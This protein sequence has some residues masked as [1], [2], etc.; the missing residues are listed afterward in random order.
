MIK[1]DTKGIILAKSAEGSSRPPEAQAFDQ[2][3][4]DQIYVNI[5]TADGL[6]IH[7]K[8]ERVVK[9]VFFLKASSFSSQLTPEDL[10]VVKA[11]LDELHAFGALAPAAKNMA[12]PYLKN[13]QALYDT[14]SAKY[15]ESVAAASQQAMTEEEKAAFDKKCDL[16][17]LD[18]LANKD[19]I[20]RS[21]EI[22]KD[23][24]PLASRSSQLA[25]VLARWNAQKTHALQLADEGKALWKEASTAHA[26]SFSVL[27]Q[28]SEMPDFP[29]DVKKK[30][31]D[32][33]ARLDQFRT[34]TDFPQ[35]ITYCQAEI[36]AYFLLN[37]LPKMVEKIKDKKYEEASVIAQKTTTLMDVHQIVAPYTQI[38]VTFKNYKDLVDDLRSRF[39]RQLAK[40]KQAEDDS[41]DDELLAEYQKA[42]DLIPDPKV[43]AKVEQL[44]A[45]IK[46]KQ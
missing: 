28:L 15:K 35:L 39:L 40:A 2:L 16:M 25:D 6:L 18:L 17:R 38:Y 3:L 46:A 27:K 29:E 41:T 42:Y 12:A 30:G 23:M 14:E 7:I 8:S 10:A 43:G 13:L 11:K 37:Q 1:E 44:K 32:L 20:K 26:G 4:Q 24:E 5:T 36:P 45:R 21:E 22:V 19:N 31:I 34:S 33:S 9:Y